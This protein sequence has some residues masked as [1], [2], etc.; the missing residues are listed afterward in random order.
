MSEQVY[1][2]CTLCGEDIDPNSRIGRIDK[3]NFHFH[4]YL[5]AKSRLEK[6]I[7][8]LNLP[9]DEWEEWLKAEAN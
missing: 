2:K 6:F 3:Y 5:A 1:D 7:T 8:I 9:D 4:C